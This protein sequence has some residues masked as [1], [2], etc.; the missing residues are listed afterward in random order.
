MRIIEFD[1]HSE[2]DVDAIVNNEIRE[3]DTVRYYGFNPQELFSEESV[4]PKFELAKFILYKNNSVFARSLCNC[5]NYRNRRS[6]AQLEVT[7]KYDSNIGIINNDSSLYTEISIGRF[8]NW[9]LAIANNLHCQIRNCYMCSAHK[10][11][12]ENGCLYCNMKNI[13]IDNPKIASI[14]ET[15][16]LNDEF[17]YKNLEE[18]KHYAQFNPIDI[19]VNN[20][21][22]IKS[23]DSLRHTK[24]L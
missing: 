18:V 11:D 6:Q 2:E 22:A 1:V 17:D 5:Q 20:H 10:Y 16:H 23:D 4:S 24:K 7:V 3:N 21:K 12:Y 9:G 19:W 8:Y 14:C 13:K 15:F